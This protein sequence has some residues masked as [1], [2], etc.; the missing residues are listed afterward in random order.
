MSLPEYQLSFQLKLYESI[1]KNEKEHETTQ[2]I[3]S[4]Q[5]WL[6][7]NIR[8]ILDESDAILQPKYQLIYTVGNQL[9]LDGGIQRWAVMQALLKRVPYHMQKLRKEH[10]NDCIEFDEIYVEKIRPNAFT[11]CRMLKDSIYPK[12][13][14]AIIKDLFDDKLEIT[15]PEMSF[16]TVTLIK[17]FLNKE[18]GASFEQFSNEFSNDFQNAILILNGILHFD[19]LKLMLVKRWRVNYGINQRGQRKMAVPFRAKDVAADMTEFGHPDVAIGFTQLSYYYS[20][21]NN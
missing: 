7:S 17:T 18:E 21:N 11:P 3:L 16:Q 15:L 13:K 2:K 1:K 8:G 9:P 4:I 19:V 10:G 14:T 20:G 12:L 6:N 5:T